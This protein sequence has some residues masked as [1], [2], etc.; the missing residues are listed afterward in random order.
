M[1]VCDGELGMGIIKPFFP[2]QFVRDTL[3]Q[4]ASFVPLLFAPANHIYTGLNG[5][6]IPI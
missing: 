1:F 6:D 5:D 3:E 2:P 4:G